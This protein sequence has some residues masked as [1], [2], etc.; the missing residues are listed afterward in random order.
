MKFIK[1][2]PFFT[3][4]VIVIVIILLSLNYF[5]IILPRL[6]SQ[7]K[8]KDNLS[9]I[10]GSTASNVIPT[11]NSSVRV[12]IKPI[13][14][15]EIQLQISNSP[16]GTQEIDFE[17]IYKSLIDAWL[18]PNEENTVDQGVIGK[19]YQ[20][21]SLWQCGEEDKNFGRKIVLGTCSSGVCRYHNIVGN[22]RLIL[23][24]KGGYG[25]KIFDKEYQI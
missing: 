9:T 17:L 24:F 3:G 13:K 21:N 15:G 7:V 10:G 4:L 8:N 19:C 1:K 23:K 16:K 14:K 11:V 2:K 25:Q 20:K 5:F 22:L 6:R 12:E 18:Q